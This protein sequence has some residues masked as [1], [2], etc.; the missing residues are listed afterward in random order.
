MTKTEEKIEKYIAEMDKL[1]ISFDKDLFTLVAKGLGPALFRKDAEV[2]S[3]G[4]ESELATV[5]KNF[6]IK[7][8]GLEDSE[9]LDTAINAVCEKMGKSNRNK[10][11][12]IFYYLL[13]EDLGL[14]GNYEATTKKEV[15]KEEPKAEAKKETKKAEKTTPKV[16]KEVAAEVEEKTTEK[17]EV[18]KEEIVATKEEVTKEEVTEEEVVETKPEEPKVDP[19]QFLADF[20][21]HK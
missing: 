2:V 13:T 11:R 4:D 1:K 15:A 20:D 17:V 10:Y 7:K 12:A 16:E 9:K 3:C 21:W 14:A 6:L 19:A 18:I 5:K 8:H